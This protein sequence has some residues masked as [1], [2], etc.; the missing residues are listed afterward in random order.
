MSRGQKFGIKIAKASGEAP[1]GIFFGGGARST[2]GGLVRGV[3]AWGDAGE[4]FKKF[5]KTNENVQF[6]ENFTGKFLIF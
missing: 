6:F 5:E 1:A 4:V 3:A 2:K